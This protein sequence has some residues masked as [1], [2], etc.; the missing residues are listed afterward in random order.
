MSQNTI[1]F[2]IR[3][4]IIYVYGSATDADSNAVK[5]RIHAVWRIWYFLLVRRNCTSTSVEAGKW[6]FQTTFSA[7]CLM[8]PIGMLAPP[9]ALWWQHKRFCAL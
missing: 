4:L 3:S 2:W 6:S 1:S 7:F 5:V 8:L 9:L